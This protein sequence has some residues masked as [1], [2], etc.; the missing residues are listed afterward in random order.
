MS[1]DPESDLLATRGGKEQ[2][3]L[4]PDL[5]RMIGIGVVLVH[6]PTGSLGCL[7]VGKAV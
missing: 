4:P 7:R 6:A 2:E 1:V 5:I 3:I